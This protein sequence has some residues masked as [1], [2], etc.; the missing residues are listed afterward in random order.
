MRNPL[1]PAAAALAAGIYLQRWLW[2]SEREYVFAAT[3]LLLLA[4]LALR[5]DRLASAVVCALLGTALCGAFFLTHWQNY[6]SPGDIRTLVEA[7]QIEMNEPARIT[8]WIAGE[9]VRRGGDESWLLRLEEIEFAQHKHAAS[10]T[11]RLQHFRW[12]EDEPRIGLRYGERLEALVRLRRVRGFR[13]PAGFDREAKALREGVVF[14][15]SVK[16][17]ELAERLPGRRGFWLP[18]RIQALRATLLSHLDEL[19]PAESQSNAVLRAML[20]GDRSALDRRVGEDFQKTGT[21][22]ALVVAGLHTAAIAGFLLLLLR[23]LRLPP[24][25][26][27]ICAI[28]GVGLFVMLAGA[29]IPTVRAG[30]MFSAYLLARL[31]FRERALLNTI[32]LAA[33]LLLVAQPADLDD[34][35]FQLSFLSV[36]LIAGIAVPWIERTSA[37]YVR[38]LRDLDNRDLELRL[39]PRQAQFR[40]ELRMFRDALRE[41]VPAWFFLFSVRAALRGWE[42]VAVA[43]VLQIGFLL[44]MAFY[45]HRAGWVAVAANLFIVPLLGL[46]VPLGAVMLAVSLFSRTLAGLLAIPLAA[47]VESMSAIARWHAGLGLASFRVP[48]PPVWLGLL[49]LLAVLLLAVSLLRPGGRTKNEEVQGR[50]T[51]TLD[52]GPW[53]LDLF[54]WLRLSA[55]VTLVVSALLIT[56]HPFRP[57]FDARRLEFAALDVGQGDAL[58]VVAPPGKVLVEDCGGLPGPYAT[59]TGEQIV[60]AYLWSRG[61]RRIDVLAVTHAHQDHV[62]GFDSVVANF[63]VGEVWLPPCLDSPP[64]AKVIEKA[65]ALHIPVR[66]WARGQATRLG[67]VGVEFLSP[68]DDYHVGRRAQ[69][70]DSLVMRLQYGARTLLLS[71]DIERKMEM[72]ML[73][74]G[75]AL[76]SD[77][78]KVPHHGSKTSSTEPFLEQVRAPYG[79]ISVAENS[80]FGHPHQEALDRLD[81]ARVRVFRTDRD[82]AVRWLTDGRRIEIGTHAWDRR[83]TRASI[84][85]W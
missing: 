30:A 79:V 72:A 38:A 24:G 33:I 16:A 35:G 4:L 21:Y 34:A 75:A 18:G 60:S 31:V 23:R 5:L 20:L 27:T 83:S 46:I 41:R 69:N 11:I 6:R 82:G 13:N 47:L 65:R 19:F 67:E 26:A 45:F 9:E 85:L 66:M 48:T 73:D 12:S 80:P 15:A 43:L 32:A 14:Y 53:T 1:L 63:P 81:A 7:G 78:L 54:R 71:G 70:N 39:A 57:Q 2:L 55:I 76:R 64:Y 25:A 22:H 40:I 51:P 36:L 10:G 44:P 42:M 37:P 49:F 62:G 74:N 61:I 77:W 58:V 68:G 28:A 50:N 17:A 8:G 59:D 84:D 52:L 56:W 3:T 29:G